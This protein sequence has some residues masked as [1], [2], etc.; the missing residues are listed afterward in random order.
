MMRSLWTA[1]SGMIAQQTNV[2]NIANNLANVNTTAYK[3]STT[4]FK[5]LL[6]QNIQAKTTSANGENKPT[7]AQVGLGVR[8]S[9]ITTQFT[10]G[11]LLESNNTY[12]MAIEGKG[13]F[14]VQGE[15]G[16]T[17]YTRNGNFQISLNADG[18]GMLATTDGLPVLNSEGEPIVLDISILP[19][20]FYEQ[21]MRQ[22]LE[23][24]GPEKLM[25]V[26]G[27]KDKLEELVEELRESGLDP[28]SQEFL[29]QY[30]NR[31]YDIAMEVATQFDLSKVS[32]DSNGEICYKD[33]LNNPKSTGVKLGVYQFA[34]PAGMNKSFDT[35]YSVTEASGE[36]VEESEGCS[37]RSRCSARIWSCSK[38]LRRLAMCR[39]LRVKDSLQST[40]SSVFLKLAEWI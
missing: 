9:S 29:T 35:L 34:N 13:F 15:D 2:D 19:E 12:A 10:Q 1:A 38:R 40:I 32:I 7:G 31:I 20:D 6:Y 18:S 8:N 14:A 39:L 23:T 21:S 33:F 27:L 25:E 26:I 17:Y 24:S 28:N 5:T 4:E 30:T 3:T 22:I 36:A 11:A 16:N 37:L